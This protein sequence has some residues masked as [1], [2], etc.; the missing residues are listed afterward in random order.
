VVLSLLL[1][2]NTA[3]AD[4]LHIRC[5]NSIIELGDRSFIVLKKCGKPISREVV[6]YTLTRDRTREL[7][8]EEWVY[9]PKH[10]LYYYLTFIGGRLGEIDSARE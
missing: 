10:G 3:L 2:A 6:G 7:H 8:I 5:G 4:R 9:G 1:R